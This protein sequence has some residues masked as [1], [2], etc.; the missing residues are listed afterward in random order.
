MIACIVSVLLGLLLATNAF[1][2]TI[3][4]A[5]ISPQPLLTYGTAKLRSTYNGNAL[6]ACKTTCTVSSSIGFIGDNLDTTTLD[7]FLAG[8]VGQVSNWNDQMGTGFSL[9][10]N[11]TESPSIQNIAIG[12]NR[13]LV[14]QGGSQSGAL[15]ALNSADISSLALTANTWTMMA[16]IQPSSSAFCNQAGAPGLSSGALFNFTKS[17]GASLGAVFNNS[18]LGG[19]GGWEV[20]DQGAFDFTSPGYMVPVTPQVLT[21]TS[22]A[23]GVRVYVNEQVRASISKSALTDTVQQIYLGKLIGSIVGSTSNAWDGQITAFMI[24]KTE[25]TESQTAFRR[26]ALYDRFSIDRRA[27][28]FDS[29]NVTIIGDSIPAGYKP[30]LGLYG[31]DDYLPPLLSHPTTT[32]IINFS[33]PGSTVTQNPAGGPAYANNVGQFPTSVPPTL[34]LSLLGRVVVIHA[35]GNDAGIGPAPLTGNTHSSTLIDNIASTATLSVGDFVAVSGLDVVS[36]IASKTAN[37]ITLTPSGPTTTL[38]GT[39]LLFTYAATSPTVVATAIQGLVTSSAAAGATATVVVSVLPRNVTYQPWLTALNVQIALI[40][41][42]TL[43]N[44][45]TFGNLGANPGPD[46]AD[47]SHLSTLGHQDMAACLAPTI[48]A[49]LP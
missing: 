34:P 22:G 20:T 29:Y 13:A 38:A 26:A 2:G 32:R 11:A 46:Y 27:T 10:G 45:N 30:T 21:V 3:Y 23:S 33:I 42:A 17:G 1:A 9:Q 24:W 37:S 36:T 7:T 6:T 39:Q 15:F 4:P 19:P 49:L 12:G 25:L 43:L 31:Y 5:D 14:F 28:D 40:T 47:A 35:G 41:G 16:V 48:N 44:C 18:Q 8:A